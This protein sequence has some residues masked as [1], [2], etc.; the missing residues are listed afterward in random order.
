MSYN[1]NESL[2]ITI[3]KYFQKRHVRVILGKRIKLR[4]HAIKIML[5]FFPFKYK[6]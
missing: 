5:C 3:L 4:S 6:R 2:Q 1:H